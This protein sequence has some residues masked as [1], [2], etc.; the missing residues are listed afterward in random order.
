MEAALFIGLI[1]V[2]IT[3]MIKMFVPAV[4]GGVTIL[5]A[6]AVGIL[7]AVFDV[8]I[9]VEDIT[10]AQGVYAALTAIGMSVLANKSGGGEKGDSTPISR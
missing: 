3:Q 10:I 5:I 8:L 1:I 4:H 2:S 6:F 7:I 9:G